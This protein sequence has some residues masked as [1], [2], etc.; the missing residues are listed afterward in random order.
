MSFCVISNIIATA[1]C[2]FFPCL[3]R[4]SIGFYSTA[5]EAKKCKDNVIMEDVPLKHEY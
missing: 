1:L 2:L 5:G 4:F 3:Y